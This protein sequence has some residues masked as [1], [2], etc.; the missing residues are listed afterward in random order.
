MKDKAT[1][2]EEMNQRL[3]DEIVVMRGKRY[4][5][6]LSWKRAEPGIEVAMNRTAHLL[7]SNIVGRRS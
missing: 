6:P 1:M 2:R 4:L 3:T 5:F 7:T